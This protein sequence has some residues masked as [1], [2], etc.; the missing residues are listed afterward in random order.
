MY[1]Y[2]QHFVRTGRFPRPLIDRL[3]EK[4]PLLYSFSYKLGCVSGR[5]HHAQNLLLEDQLIVVAPGGMEEAIRPH[6]EKYQIKWQK[7]RGF[8]RLAID[9]QTPIFLA[10]CPHSDDLYKV[11]DTQV[12]RWCYRHLRI[13]MLFMRGLGPTLMPRPV[14]LKHFISEAIVPPEKPDHYKSMKESWMNSTIPF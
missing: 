5:Q 7:K 9:T 13:P 4:I 6:T 10:F 1:A 3:F 14:K 2:A 11:Y 12:T 8:V